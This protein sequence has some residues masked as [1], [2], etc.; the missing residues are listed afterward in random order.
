MGDSPL[1][2]PAMQKQFKTMGIVMGS[3]FVWNR[4]GI[5]MDVETAAG[6]QNMW[7]LRYFYVAMQGCQVLLCLDL[8]RRTRAREAAG[9]VERMQ[10]GERCQA[11]VNEQWLDGEVSESGKKDSQ[12]MSVLVDEGLLRDRNVAGL[13]QRHEVRKLHKC[14]RPFSPMEVA[15]H[16]ATDGSDDGSCKRKHCS[17]N[18]VG[19]DVCAASPMDV[20][21]DD[22]TVTEWKTQAMHD[23]DQIFADV[24]QVLVSCVIVGLIHYKW[25]TYQPLLLQSVL[26]PFNTLDKP[27]FCVNYR[28]E[29]IKRPFAKA[30][31][32]PMMDM[33]NEQMKQLGMADGKGKKNRKTQKAA[34]KAA[35][36]AKKR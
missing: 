11:M 30:G 31:A 32:N 4:S 15:Q 2:S 13:N 19:C 27:L 18:N 5:S 10:K 17:S 33:Y 3:M 8:W 23:S 28:G 1:S 7:Y 22:N 26:M 21:W 6:A 12:V 36:K 20:D 16:K 24:K 14:E 9:S 29:E 25:G 34:Q 35:L